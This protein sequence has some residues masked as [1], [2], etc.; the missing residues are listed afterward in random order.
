MCQ[1]EQVQ[2]DCL[3]SHALIEAQA[4]DYV[5]DVQMRLIVQPTSA[6]LLEVTGSKEMVVVLAF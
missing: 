3:R 1:A 2:I 6:Q 5:K 4:K